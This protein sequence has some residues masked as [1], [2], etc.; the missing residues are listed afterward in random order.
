MTPAESDK[1]LILFFDGVCNLCNAAVQFIIKRDS[2][3][4]ILFAPLQSPRGIL[5]KETVEKAIGK[6]TNSLIFLDK[7]QYYTQ[8]SAALKV[9]GYLNK[10]W[11]LLKIFWLVPHPFRDAVYALIARKRYE[12]FGKQD[13]C[14]MP[15]AELKSRFLN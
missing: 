7:G 10:G 5:A 12:W 1:E 8:S 14:M 4:R 15:T 2:N 9:A 13:H 11:P 3:S 6:A